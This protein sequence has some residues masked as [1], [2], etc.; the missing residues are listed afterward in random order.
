MRRLPPWLRLG[1][2]VIAIV[3]AFVIVAVSG[4]L[5]ADKVRD[6][7]SGYGVAG[8]I[9]FIFVAAALNC[10]CFPGPL[11]AGAAGLLFGTALGTPVAI[12]STTLSAVAACLISRFVAG[13]VVE[14]VFGQRLKQ[15]AG[16]VERH[17]FLSTFYVRLLPGVPFTVFNYA[18]GLTRIN[19]ALFALAT[20]IGCAP[21]TFAYVALGGSFGDFSDPTTIIAIAILVVMALAGGIFAWAQATG[22]ITLPGSAAAKS[23]PDGRSEAPQ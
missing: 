8:P 11:L 7:M 17:S 23:S 22:R 20:L 5:S 3:S 4:S 18:V 2:L 1:G 16:L 13:D 15:L 19:V 14:R 10:A 12:V 21:R 6:W 9:V